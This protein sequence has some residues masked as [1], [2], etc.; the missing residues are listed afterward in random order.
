MIK[1]REKTKCVS[2]FDLIK[3][4]ERKR[5][6]CYGSKKKTEV[7]K[8]QATSVL[9]RTYKFTKSDRGLIDKKKEENIQ[10]KKKCLF[11][12]LSPSPPPPPE[13]INF[14]A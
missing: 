14:V 2:V 4:N 7:H 10:K 1:L 9:L 5:L 12:P 8:K 3:K 11:L 6:F 13:S